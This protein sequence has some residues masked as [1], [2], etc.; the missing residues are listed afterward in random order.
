MITLKD[1]QD[2]PRETS[3][4]KEPRLKQNMNEKSKNTIAIEKVTK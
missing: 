4:K 1:S 3:G 2:K